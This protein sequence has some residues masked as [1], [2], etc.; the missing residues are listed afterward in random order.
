MYPEQPDNSK[1][2]KVAA[3]A[4]IIIAGIIIAAAVAFNSSRDTPQTSTTTSQQSQTATD[5]TTAQ[6]NTPGSTIT[7]TY[8]DG[9]YTA[10]S[11]YNVPRSFENIKVTL[12]VADNVVTDS[13][14][15]N[16]EGDRES[17]EW[18][19]KFTSVYKTQVVGK[20]LSDINLT[21]VAG[22]SDTAEGF[23]DALEQIKNQAKS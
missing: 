18:Q 22:A 8:K 11:D 2:K 10:D 17:A 4:V 6:D 12:T 13:Q 16:S 3:F 23:N 7:A 9:T 20:K 15:V 1:Q 19:E 14:I 5:P 21:Y